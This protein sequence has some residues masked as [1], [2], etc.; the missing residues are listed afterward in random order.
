MINKKKRDG[1][2]EG[3]RERTEGGREYFDLLA[4]V[5]DG[6]DGADDGG[7]ACSERLQ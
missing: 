1:R 5:G 7:S 2:E 3:E 4:L 6:F